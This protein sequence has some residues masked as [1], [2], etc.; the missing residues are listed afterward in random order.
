LVQGDLAGEVRSAALLGLIQEVGGIDDE[1][2]SGLVK[3][4][5]GVPAEDP[6]PEFLTIRFRLTF[7]Q[8]L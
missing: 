6:L 3:D 8:V 4:V 7:T 2:A 5:F 1:G